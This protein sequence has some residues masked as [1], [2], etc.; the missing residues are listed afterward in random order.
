MGTIANLLDRARAS[1]SLEDFGESSFREGLEVLVRSA[2]TEARLTEHGRDLLDGQIVDLL[3]RRLEI[4]HWYALHP[5]IDE[6]EIVA[7]LI[8]LGLP[9]TGSTALSGL[10]AED[11][12][13][14]SIRTWEYHWPSP[15]PKTE[16]EHCDPRIQRAVELLEQQD[17]LVPG[18]KSMLPVGPTAPMEC[19]TFMAYDF[20]SNL[21]SAFAKI[22][23]YVDWLYYSADLVPTYR[24][25]KR[26]LKLLQWQCPP[27]RWRLKNPAH[28]LFM[29][30]LDSVFP[31]A[32]FW[33]T[34]REITSVIPSVVSVFKEYAQ[35]YTDNVDVKYLTDT[36]QDAWELGMRRLIAF[37]DAGNDHRFFDVQFEEMQKD[38][39]CVIENLYRFLGEE[40]SDV[41]RERMHEWRLNTP[42]DKHGRHTYD[43]SKYGI[44]LDDLARRFA[45]YSRRFAVLQSHNREA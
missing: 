15:P 39:I 30:A 40:L 25:V 45:F 7:P 33:M 36:N 14:R 6:Q 31:D 1:T 41:A 8:G 12:A 28:I 10:L 27:R 18:L 32:R 17:Q 24:Y 20:K 38:P 44:S 29:D 5:E 23:S 11:P 26:V 22:P 13:V 43:P 9:R 3:S 37:R 19:Q 35:I 2:D 21:F 16:T 4:E 34:H 42:R